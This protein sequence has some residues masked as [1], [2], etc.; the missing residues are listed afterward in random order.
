MILEHGPW[1]A[2]ERWPDPPE[3]S[4]QRAIGKRSSSQVLHYIRG[5]DPKEELRVS[6][7]CCWFLCRYGMQS[8]R[9][10]L[11]WPISEVQLGMK[12]LGEW[13][14][15]EAPRTGAGPS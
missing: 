1:P 11:T 5:R 4:I 6:M 8:Y 12:L 10:V 13:I 7:K 3:T 9:E 14:E 2:Y 15:K